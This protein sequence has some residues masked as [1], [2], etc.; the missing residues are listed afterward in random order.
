MVWGKDGEQKEGEVVLCS[1]LLADPA[2]WQILKLVIFRFTFGGLYNSYQQRSCL[3]P[4]MRHVS[5]CWLCRTPSQSLLPDVP[6][7]LPVMSPCF[8]RNLFIQGSFSNDSNPVSFCRALKM[9]TLTYKKEWSKLAFTMCQTCSKHSMYFN[10]F[11]SHNTLLNYFYKDRKISYITINS[12][13]VS[14][15]KSKTKAEVPHNLPA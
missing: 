11:H 15:L 12:Q 5:S 1:S 10:L 13:Q 14:G 7:W 6:Q 4:P 8:S 2:Q 9:S 3:R